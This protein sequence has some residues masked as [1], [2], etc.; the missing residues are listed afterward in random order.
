MGLNG[1]EA[2]SQDNNAS[3]T[4]GDGPPPQGGS[5]GGSEQPPGQSLGD[6]AENPTEVSRFLKQGRVAAD[7]FYLLALR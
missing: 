4:Q 6:A 3:H 2:T 5:S 1:E 7:L